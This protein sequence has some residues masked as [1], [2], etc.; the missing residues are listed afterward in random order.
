ML[1]FMDP[2]N[3]LLSSYDCGVMTSDGFMVSWKRGGYAV[4]GVE[5]KLSARLSTGDSNL[6]LLGD[7]MVIEDVFNRT[8]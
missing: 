2:P 3:K 1:P 5:T 8:E 7:D 4:P 6:R